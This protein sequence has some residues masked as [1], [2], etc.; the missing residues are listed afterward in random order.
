[1]SAD[2]FRFLFPTEPRLLTSTRTQRPCLPPTP[3][4]FTTSALRP[5]SENPISRLFLRIQATPLSL[6]SLSGSPVRDDSDPFRHPPKSLF[7]E[8]VFFRHA[9]PAGDCYFVYIVD[10]AN[11]KTTISECFADNDPGSSLGEYETLFIETIGGQFFAVWN[12]RQTQA[13]DNRLPMTSL[14]LTTNFF[15]PKTIL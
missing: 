9:D 12:R 13:N 2:C 15:T 5:D 10:V 14:E 1:M 6:A 7:S 8:L 3:V 11:N 4:S